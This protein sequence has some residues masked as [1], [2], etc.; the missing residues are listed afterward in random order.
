MEPSMILENNDYNVEGLIFSSMPLYEIVFK[1]VCE[2]F[3]DIKKQWLQLREF[4]I[5]PNTATRNRF[6]KYMGPL[7]DF[8]KQW[9]W[10]REVHIFL[11]AAMRDHFQ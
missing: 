3:M 1:S 7:N 5:Y 6:Q 2:A 10:L 4:D 11:H 8:Q 9:L